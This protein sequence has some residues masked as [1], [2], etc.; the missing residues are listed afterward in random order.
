VSLNVPVAMR[1][2]KEQQRKMTTAGPQIGERFT[3]VP[4]AWPLPRG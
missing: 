2:L 1:E 4:V 3:G